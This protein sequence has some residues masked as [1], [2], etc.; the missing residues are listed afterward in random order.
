MKIADFGITSFLDEGPVNDNNGSSAYFA[1]EVF[2]ISQKMAANEPKNYDPKRAMIW[3]LGVLLFYLLTGN[4]PFGLN[5]Y[6][7]QHEVIKYKQ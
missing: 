5:R 6:D 3:S 4:L 7:V 1:P 2:E